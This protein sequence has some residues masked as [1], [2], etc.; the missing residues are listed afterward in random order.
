MKYIREQ[1]IDMKLSG[2]DL[3]LAFV[4]ETIDNAVIELIKANKQDIVA[5]LRAIMATGRT[6]Q[7]PQAPEQ[8][9]YPVTSSQ[10]RFWI[11]C[12]M[13][14]VN[15]A[16]NLPLVLRL[17]GP[18]VINSLQAA[19]D[20]LIDRHEI[21]RT[22]F[23]AAA[24]GTIGQ[25]VLRLQDFSFEI[26]VCSIADEQE[27]QHKIAAF[28]RKPFELREAALFKARLI[29]KH[30]QEHYLC[31]NIH[32]IIADG[33]SLEIL[34]TELMHIYNGL[35]TQVPLQ[36]PALPVQFK[37]YAVWMNN[38]QQVDSDAAYWKERFSGELPVI[39]LPTFQP[40]P[41]LKTYN[42]DVY[43]HACD[44]G[45]LKRVRDFSNE[46]QGTV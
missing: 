33:A 46:Q 5:Y 15:R 41:A 32:H 1:G 39:N 10:L 12:Q 2:E 31:L 14:D 13:E 7:I 16:Y 21:L 20:Q 36:L 8:E 18:L 40:R 34:L 4:N 6:E 30:E 3:E 22:H 19:F 25:K 9:I 26:E 35:I 27:M 37:D 29:H 38:K 17:E 28:I 42:G 23:T 11:L 24:D 43:M 45:L 44:P